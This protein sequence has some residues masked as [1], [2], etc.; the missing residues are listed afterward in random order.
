VLDWGLD[1]LIRIDE[2]K[3]TAP[4]W[5]I[6][7]GNLKMK[8]LACLIIIVFVL[9]GCTSL[10]TIQKSKSEVQEELSH[11][12]L[13]HPGDKVR[14][15]T[16]DGKQYDLKVVSIADGGYVKGQDVNIPIKDIDLIEKR[17]FSIGKTSLL[18]GAAFLLF[19]MS[20]L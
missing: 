13:I 8:I 17:R 16:N 6:Y 20:Q 5:S 4:N 18:S 2:I 19:V 15:I 14:I 10:R 3:N 7:G 1:A 12:D 9:S 11:G